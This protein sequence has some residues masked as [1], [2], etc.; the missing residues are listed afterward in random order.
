MPILC[1]R[2]SVLTVCRR[3]VLRKVWPCVSCVAQAGSK[4]FA[5]SKD[6]TCSADVWAAQSMEDSIVSEAKRRYLGSAL[7]AFILLVLFPVPT[8]ADLVLGPEELVQANGTNVFV[9]G[10]SVP[11]FV[12]W[13]GDDLKDLVV[14]EGGG[15]SP[16]GKVRV[17]LNVGTQFEPHFA[18]Y[19][20]AQSQGSDLVVPASGCLGIFPRVVEANGDGR[21][22]LLVGL[23]DGSVKL[24][25]NVNTD[26][27]P[28]FDGG[29]FLQVGPPGSKA[30]INVG[31]RATPVL[32]DW[33]SDGK[34]DLVV[35]ALDGKLHIYINE[36][37]DSSP[38]FRTVSF[39]QENGA[40]LVVPTLRLSPHIMDLDDDGKKD[41]LT[42]NTEGQLLFYSNVGSD[43]APA[44]SGYVLVETDSVSI[45]LPGSARSRPFACDWTSDGFPD[46]LIGT[47]DGLVHLYQGG[48]VIS[49]SSD[50]VPPRSNVSLHL[51]AYP[52]PFNPRV[53]ISFLLGETQNVHLYV[54]DL[55]GRRVA[56][57]VDGTLAEGTHRLT[58]KGI[59]DRGREVS[60]GIYFLRLD[61][62]ATSSISKMILLR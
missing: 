48:E 25:L 32:A 1:A 47:G 27:D 36:G 45:D 39:A 7:F 58:W 59:D 22:D 50:D 44:F 14:G 6:V 24:Y 53:T 60:S 41:I 11:S 23:A 4:C 37:T 35:G 18:S 33:N 34:R 10:Y 5:Q 13:N 46:V 62:E 30:N 20:Y 2:H 56:R 17:Y 26:E 21:K 3:H 12:F 28:R 40:P 57:L 31:A 54:C 51:N 55:V 19:F 15:S 42:G 52:N 43:E 8:H 9:S 16:E 29:T 38:D 49:V 61:V